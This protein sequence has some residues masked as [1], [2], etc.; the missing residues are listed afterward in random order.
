MS[1]GKLPKYISQS[2]IHHNIL[3]LFSAI[4]E[5]QKNIEMNNFVTVVLASLLVF[6]SCG[7]SKTPNAEETKDA[8]NSKIEFES[9]TFDF[10]KIPFSSDGTCVFTFT[11]TSE[12]DLIV[13]IVRTSCGCTNPEWP[14]DPIE[15][16]KTGEIKVKYNTQIV[17]T[18]Q[19]SITV[20]S[21]AVNSPV[22]LLIKGEVQPNPSVAS[23]SSTKK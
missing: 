10:G 13:N 14:K 2:A 16:G 19:K 7:Q 20:F 15:P 21:N 23:S 11:N 18:F 4:F 3:T 9:T 5:W 6:S 8:N 1:R 22:K 12:E 17:G